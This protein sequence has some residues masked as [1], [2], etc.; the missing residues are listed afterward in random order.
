MKT[1]LDLDDAL[2]A[3]AKALAAQK[4]VS[5]TRLIEEGLTLRLRAARPVRRAPSDLPAFP[6]YHGEG[7]LVAGLNPSSNRALLDALDV[8]DATDAIDVADTATP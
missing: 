1:T 2:V 7:G 3:R 4:R 5:L 6:V 8:I